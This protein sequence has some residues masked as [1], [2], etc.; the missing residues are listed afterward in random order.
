MAH[1]LGRYMPALPEAA[2]ADSGAASALAQ[3]VETT[4]LVRLPDGREF[5][6][7][8]ATPDLVDRLA[9]FGAEHEDMEDEGLAL[10]W[11]HGPSVRIGGQ[12]FFPVSADD[13]EREPE[14][15]GGRQ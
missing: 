1:G 2:L 6:I 4:D 9:C 10:D 11:M 13:G 7:T 3:I 8:P 5:F 14:L 15:W 12:W